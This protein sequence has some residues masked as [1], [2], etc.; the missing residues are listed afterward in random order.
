MSIETVKR[1]W[2]LNM[3]T[4]LLSNAEMLTAEAEADVAAGRVPS[5]NLS[6]GLYALLGRARAELYGWNDSTVGA[7]FARVLEK[8]EPSGG[9]AEGSVLDPYNDG[10]QN[11]ANTVYGIT[12]FDTVGPH[13]LAAYDNG[14]ITI[15]D[16]DATID[17]A[18]NW[19]ETNGLPDYS[20]HPN[21]HGKPI[22]LNIV[23]AAAAF[24]LHARLR[25]GP[26]R[27][28]RATDQGTA[29]MS[30]IKGGYRQFQPGVW[31]WPYLVG[32]A[33]R[34]GGPWNAVCADLAWHWL[35]AGQG[36]AAQ[37]CE[38]GPLG[39]GELDLIGGVVRLLYLPACAGWVDHYA[40]RVAALVPTLP[41]AGAM[42][43]WAYM[44]ARIH[45]A[46]GGP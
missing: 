14:K 29:W 8:R 30:A 9:Y 26:E 46:H 7:R 16:L 21:D 3:A 15:G 32:G 39:F 5:Q 25:T 20:R 42:A 41:N 45:T 22:V 27:K 34:Q 12:T 37:Q 33:S 28:T 36:A 18:L 6:A 40:G 31:G 24:L 23:A 4:G 35:A 44:C 43:A 2:F 11:P 10:T 38:D 19:P 17:C 13:L 1:G